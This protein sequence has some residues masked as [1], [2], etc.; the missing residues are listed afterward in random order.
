M[1]GV[2]GKAGEMCRIRGRQGM[3]GGRGKG[4]ARA[5]EFSKGGC[6]PL[7]QAVDAGAPGASWFDQR[8]PHAETHSLQPV[9]WRLH[10]SLANDTPSA[11]GGI[12]KG[13]ELD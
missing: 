2:G 3:V 9:P 13:T 12:R 5:D 8:C 10:R 11:D 1:G 6:T 7:E 4:V